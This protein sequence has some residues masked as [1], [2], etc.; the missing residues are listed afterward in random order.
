LSATQPKPTKRRQGYVSS[1]WLPEDQ[2]AWIKAEARA[3]GLGMGAYL[4]LCAEERYERQA[5]HNG[6][7]NGRHGVPPDG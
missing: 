7:G 3:L 1:I 5:H 6:N 2:A 4:R